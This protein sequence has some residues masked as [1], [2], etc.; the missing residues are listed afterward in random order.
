M[1]DFPVFERLLTLGAFWWPLLVPAGLFFLIL[2]IGVKQRF[3]RWPVV[4]LTV[5]LLL[6][7]AC[8]VVKY[9]IPEGWRV[10][11][12]NISEYRHAVT[13]DKP[14]RM[15]RVLI[16]AGSVLQLRPGFDMA[17]MAQATLGNVEEIRLPEPA[18]LFG[19]HVQ[20]VAKHWVYWRV[21]LVGTQVIDGWPCRGN[22]AITRTGKLVECALARADTAFGYR[23]P[24]GARVSHADGIV[25]V[26]IPNSGTTIKFDAD[27]GRLV[28]ATMAHRSQR[29]HSAWEVP[30]EINRMAV[31]FADHVRVLKRD[32]KVS[33]STLPRGT[34]LETFAP[35]DADGEEQLILRDISIVEL[36]VPAAIHGVRLEGRVVHTGGYWKGKLAAPQSAAGWPCK[37]VVEFTNAGAVRRCTFSRTHV[38]RG[39]RMP[40]ETEVSVDVLRPDVEYFDLPGSRWLS[41]DGKTG[42]L[43]QAG[44]GDVLY[45]RSRDGDAVPPAVTAMRADAEDS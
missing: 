3:V 44:V 12:E 16:P 8:V 13:L 14:T 43:R 27:S 33:A 36:D 31:D 37:G 28:S 18:R 10:A 25:S 2:A 41:F 1:V 6:P 26:N 15:S 9:V 34:R 40:A 24:A 19:V 17:D 32:T 45:L 42:Q 23:F 39:Y 22:I 35:F 4:V 29:F 7:V 21:N 5:V 20:G 38:V 11:V 30:P